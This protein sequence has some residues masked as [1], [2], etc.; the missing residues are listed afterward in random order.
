MYQHILFATDL[1]DSSKEAMDKALELSQKLNVK[2]SMVHVVEP[3]PS[4]GYPG[5]TDVESPYIDH[6]KEKF[7][8]LGSEHNIPKENLHFELGPTKTEILDLA[9]NVKA[10]LIIVG[11]HGRHGLSR[12]LGSTSNAVLNSATIDVLVV[13]PKK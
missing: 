10:D 3:F 1:T 11:S 13:R 8:Q 4:Y 12:L 2:L 9:E 6:V 7:F 5:I